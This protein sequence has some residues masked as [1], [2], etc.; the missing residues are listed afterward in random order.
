MGLLQQGRPAR[1]LRPGHGHLGQQHRQLNR[2]VL[3]RVQHGGQHAAARRVQRRRHRHRHHAPVLAHS[4]QTQ[5]GGGDVDPL[6]GP[7]RRR[8]A[9]RAGRAGGGARR[10]ARRLG[11]VRRHLHQPIQ[12][13]AAGQLHPARPVGVRHD[14][15]GQLDDLKG[16]GLR[17]AAAPAQGLQYG[18]HHPLVGMPGGGGGAQMALVDQPPQPL[19][20]VDQPHPAHGGP[21]GPGPAQ[22]GQFTRLG[23]F[24]LRE[25]EALRVVFGPG[26]ATACRAAGQCGLDLADVPQPGHGPFLRGQRHRLPQ[27]RGRWLSGRGTGHREAGRGHQMGGQH[28][29]GGPVLGGQVHPSVDQAGHLPGAALEPDL[30][31]HLQTPPTRS[32]YHVL[33]QLSCCSRRF[34]SSAAGPGVRRVCSPSGRVRSAASRPFHSAW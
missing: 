32:G 25:G 15:L 29:P 10:T 13:P 18:G 21:A 30:S 22:R 2:P 31:A 34:P 26:R 20:L 7:Q 5:A 24:P 1:A 27:R 19:P 9:A 17:P 28:T 12:R 23:L 16:G 6:G 8:R 4:P 11:R 3:P 14:L 33:A